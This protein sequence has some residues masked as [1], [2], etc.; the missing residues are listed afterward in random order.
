MKPGLKAAIFEVGISERG[1]MGKIADML[2]PT[3]ALITGVGHAHM[4]G[5]GSLGDVAAEK[6][7][8][9]SC[10]GEANIGIVN[11]DQDALSVISYP[12]PVLKFGLKT[13]NQIQARK[14]TVKNILDNHNLPWNFQHILLDY[15]EITINYISNIIA[16]NTLNKNFNKLSN[17]IEKWIYTKISYHP[18]ITINYV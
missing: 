7:A 15:S 9:F 12:Y 16:N 17:N 2:R 18:N 1:S 13:C 10:F 14:I 5:L 3:Y 8:I 6:R 4:A 11:G